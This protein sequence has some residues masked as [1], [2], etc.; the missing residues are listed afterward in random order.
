MMML[1]E[2]WLE[3]LEMMMISCHLAGSCHYCSL[4][5]L[6]PPDNALAGLLAGCLKMVIVTTVVEVKVT[7]S[8]CSF[9]LLPVAPACW[10]RPLILLLDSDISSLLMVMMAERAERYSNLSL[11]SLCPESVVNN[12]LCPNSV[13]LQPHWLSL[14]LILPTLAYCSHMLVLVVVG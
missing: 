1:V 12:S 13:S 5:H 10:R 8:A 2:P 9:L 6:P 4:G 7:L 11:C 3:W 14:V